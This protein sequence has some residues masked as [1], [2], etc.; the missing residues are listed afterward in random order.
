MFR[1]ALW[2][3]N[4]LLTAWPEAKLEAIRWSSWLGV[5]L[6]DGSWI[7]PK[8]TTEEQIVI[9][10]CQDIRAVYGCVNSGKLFRCFVNIVG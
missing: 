6:N 4:G 3:S 1:E 9:Y 5:D 7:H 10:E 8:A 2:A